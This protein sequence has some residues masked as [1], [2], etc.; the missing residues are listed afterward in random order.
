[1]LWICRG[2]SAAYAPGQPRCPNCQ[3][4]AYDEE[5][6]MPKIT[7]HGGPSNDAAPSRTEWVS[8]HGPELHHVPH[9]DTVRQHPEEEPSPG[10]SSETSP[11]K[12][13]NS[14][15]PNSS[16]ARSRARTTENPSSRRR[17]AASSA[18][19]TDGDPTPADDKG[20]E[21]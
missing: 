11:S 14:A 17:T 21:A 1:M 16:A 20:D 6:T 12:P 9:G 10:T 4:T 15:K 18:A 13:S 8:E 3:D 2:C 19:S 7:L 5:G